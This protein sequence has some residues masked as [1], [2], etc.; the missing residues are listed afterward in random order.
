M[1]DFSFDSHIRKKMKD[2]ECSSYNAEAFSEL[3]AKLASGTSTPWY[4]AHRTAL[5]ATATLVASTFLNFYIINPSV[6]KEAK[7]EAVAFHSSK[8]IDSLN[9]VI[10][11]LEKSTPGNIYIVDP[12]T[13]RRGVRAGSVADFSSVLTAIDTSQRSNLKLLLGS[14]IYLPPEIF[15]ELQKWNMIERKGDEVWLVVSRQEAGDHLVHFRRSA[16][17]LP[18]LQE[19]IASVKASIH[20]IAFTRR[21]KSD[22]E[23]SRKMR[24][25]LEKHYFSG[26]G[27]EL[28]PH[29]DLSI[30]DFGTG[31]RRIIPRVGIVADWVISPR[32]SIET[33]IDY[34]VPKFTVRDNFQGLT[35]NNDRTIGTLQ[36]AEVGVRALSL[37]LSW[38]FRWWMTEKDQLTFRVGFTP[39][40]SLRHQYIYSYTPVNKSPEDD[41]TVRMVEQSDGKGFY[42]STLGV[43]AGITRLLKSNRKFEVSLYGEKSLGVNGGRALEGTFLGIKTAYWLKLR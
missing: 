16:A 40:F 7:K 29:G 20:A 2:Y 37:P 21:S 15:K 10:R 5:I 22:V 41:L 18:Q 13:T 24:N 12:A 8:V 30:G 42:S 9:L 27:I 32:F 31:S 17:E 34:S 36:S 3:Q 4:V 25:S 38:K 14:E 43:S 33:G 39:Y 1:D 23:I 26:L 35:L 6:L 19:S 11:D 28:A